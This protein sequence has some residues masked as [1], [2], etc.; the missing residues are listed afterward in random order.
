MNPTQ[1]EVIIIRKLSQPGGFGYRPRMYRQYRNRRGAYQ[2]LRVGA[3]EEAVGLLGF[4]HD[5]DQV[6]L[7]ELCKFDAVFSNVVAVT[8]I[9]M[10]AYAFFM[11]YFF[12]L[13]GVMCQ[14]QSGFFAFHLS[15]VENEYF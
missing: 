2:L 11:Q 4:S 12:Y 9:K 3:H 6:A 10:G 1:S 7:M 15:G 5:A 13:F 8:F 14:F